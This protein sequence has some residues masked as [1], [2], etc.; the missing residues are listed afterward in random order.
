MFP[1]EMEVCNSKTISNIHTCLLFTSFHKCGIENYPSPCANSLYK[2]FKSITVVKH[3]SMCI[4]GI[5]FQEH[6]PSTKENILSENKRIAQLYLAML[7][8]L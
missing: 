8:K 5:S 1:F 2:M 6:T 3:E 7:L 4:S